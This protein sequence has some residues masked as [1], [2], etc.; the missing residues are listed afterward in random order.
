MNGMT[1]TDMF[2]CFNINAALKKMFVLH[3]SAKQ[4]YQYF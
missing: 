1:N 3:I 2:I 4:G